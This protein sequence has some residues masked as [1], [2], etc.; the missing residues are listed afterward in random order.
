MIRIKN[1]GSKIVMR[2]PLEDSYLSRII[3]RSG[4]FDVWKDT[5]RRYGHVH[6]YNE[7]ELRNMFSNCGF[8]VTASRAYPMAK[9]SK[10]VWEI[11]R[12]ILYPISIYSTDLMVQ[13]GGGF[14]IF[15]L[16]VI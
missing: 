11:L 12:L 16:E 7:K 8:D 5:E 4:I 14:K 9:R 10:W 6:H 15:Y 1:F 3:I 13:V 2:I